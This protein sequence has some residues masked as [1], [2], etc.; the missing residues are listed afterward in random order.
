MKI[1]YPFLIVLVS[2]IL[3]GCPP[4][5]ATPNNNIITIYNDSYEV[6]VGVYVSPTS[7]VNWG[8]NQLDYVL[9]PGDSVTIY[10]IPDDCYDISA[11]SDAGIYWEI[12]DV[13]LFGGADV[14]YSLYNKKQAEILSPTSDSPKA[15][16]VPYNPE[17]SSFKKNK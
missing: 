17:S 4:P 11:E 10:G 6:I 15:Y 9:Y 13:C 8:S 7:S 16:A 2:I 14:G 1:C 5:V 3:L 12:Y